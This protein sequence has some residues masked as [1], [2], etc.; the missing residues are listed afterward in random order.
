MKKKL[1]TKYKKFTPVIIQVILRDILFKIFG[2]GLLDPS[3][4]PMDKNGELVFFQY[5][6]AEVKNKFTQAKYFAQLYNT[7]VAVKFFY[8]K[9]IAMLFECEILKGEI[10]N[11]KISLSIQHKSLLPI[12]LINKKNDNSEGKINLKINSE[13]FEFEGMK[14]NSFHYLPISENAEIDI[15][16]NREFILAEPIA[17]YQSIKKP[18]KKLVLSLFID[19]LS[20]FV[21]DRNFKSIMPNTFKF[22]EDGVIFKNCMAT[23][24]WTQ[25]S[26]PS[27]FTGLNTRNH[28][29]YR[30]K[31][32]QVFGDNNKLISEYFKEEGYLTSQFCSNGK[33]SPFYNYMRGFDRTIYKQNI[34]VSDTIMNVIE[35]L[36]TFKNRSNFM[37]V[38][39]FDLHHMLQSI[40]STSVA[41]EIDLKWQNYEIPHNKSV[42]Q[43]YDEKQIQWY[44]A[45]LKRL[46]FYIKIIYDYV[47]ENYKDDEV[48]ISIVSDHGQAYLGNQ[49][50]LLSI[51]KLKVPMMFKSTG[52]SDGFKDE[53]IQNTDFLP[54]LLSLSGIKYDNMNI[55]GR[56]PNCLGGNKEREF[57]F[58]ESIY[59]N[60]QYEAAFY[61]ENSYFYIKTKE[62]I[63]SIN[64]ISLENIEYKLIDILTGEDKTL[65]ETQKVNFYL[66]YLQT[67]IEKT[68]N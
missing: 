5:P 18:K 51:Q 3:A 26:V 46:D 62:I 24:E 43:S 6:F 41:S 7:S 54:S 53:L 10:Y 16:A 55:D 39:L 27:L 52:L 34:P 13:M 32:V 42:F 22:F 66:K 49:K 40:P 58:S 11:K 29:I 19:G 65:V 38:T 9:S 15:S 50:E 36:R 1:I 25:T 44:Y 56:L 33:K 67:Y 14:Q 20:S 64:A 35:H 59:P 30:P 8:D 23:S 17:L 60:R 2:K 61:D 37:W 57:S 28:K 4:F 48:V 31:E 12:S 47:T 63:P 68:A 21:F 45:E